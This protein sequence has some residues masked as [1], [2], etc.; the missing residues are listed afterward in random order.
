MS[1][2][3]LFFLVL[4]GQSLYG[5]TRLFFMALRRYR[6]FNDLGAFFALGVIVLAMAVAALNIR[7]FAGADIFLIGILAAEFA[8][9]KWIDRM[10]L[11]DEQDLFRR[12]MI[13]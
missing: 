4:A 7:A 8:I 13:R 5:T 1:T 6:V 11:H 12:A 9:R 10:D 3:V 2:P